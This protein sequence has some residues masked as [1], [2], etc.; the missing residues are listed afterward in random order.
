MATELGDLKRLKLKE[1]WPH[2]ERD[3]TP[4]LCQPQ[5][6]AE[7]SRALGLDEL[8][9]ER[10]EVPVG[11]Y[12]ADILARDPDGYV[13]IENQ[14]GRTNHDHLGK[15]LTYGATLGAAKIIWV[16]EEFTDEHQRAI[17]WL[18]DRTTDDLSLYAVKLEVFRIDES[19]PAVRFNVVGEP[20]EIVK[21]ASAAKAAAADSETQQLRLEFWKAVQ[22]RLLEKRILVSTQTPTGR[23]WFDVP[24]GRS[25]IHLSNIANI[26]EN[27][28]GIRVYLHNRVAASALEQLQRDQKAIEQ[29]LGEKLI[30]NPNPDARD[31]VI[32]LFRDADLSDK[33]RR[34]EQVDWLVDRIERFIRTFKPR[35]AKLRFD[36]AGEAS[37]DDRSGA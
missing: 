28:I 9:L 35:A 18:N 29:E 11:Q 15:L 17:E 34:D 31:K 3:F 16:A 23:Y 13:V 4:W 7:L 6:L 19:R 32:G 27:K 2:E 26:T 5:N 10:A 20:S 37:R 30:W 1:V 22:K 8:Q 36:D 14:F 33:N 12:S 21:A 24:L 25:G